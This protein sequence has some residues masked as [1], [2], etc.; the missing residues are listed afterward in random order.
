MAINSLLQEAQLSQRGRACFV[1]VCSQLQHT[2]SAVFLLPITAASDL[3]VHAHLAPW[4][5]GSNLE[6]RMNR[7]I[8]DRP[9]IQQEAIC[10]QW[11]KQ[12]LILSL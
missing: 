2:Y 5:P 11:F 4:A 12:R 8:D 10:Y 3:L 7:A 1:F 9:D 6:V